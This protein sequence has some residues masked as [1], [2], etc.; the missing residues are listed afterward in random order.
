MQRSA[1][2]NATMSRKITNP[3]HKEKPKMTHP[4]KPINNV[5]NDVENIIGNSIANTVAKAVVNTV[6]NKSREGFQV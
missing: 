1:V 5:G 4:G 3:Q 2:S 6:A